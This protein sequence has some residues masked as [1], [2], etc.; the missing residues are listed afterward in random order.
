MAGYAVLVE[1]LGS[2]EDLRA[3][4]PEIDRRARM[5]I[6]KATD[7][8]RAEGARDIKEQVAFPSTYLTGGQGAAR[9]SKQ[10]FSGRL[11]GEVTGRFRPTSLA[12]FVKGSADPARTRG[13]TLKFE[14]EP[15]RIAYSGRMFLMRL[16]AGN[17]DIETQNNLGV[18][19]RL[20]P[21][22]QVTGRKDGTP[23]KTWRGLAF[24]YGPSVDQVFRDVAKDNAPATLLIL[25]Q[26]FLRLM[27]VKGI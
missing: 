19:I 7:K 14:V 1:G 11:R 22:E 27:N 24:L 26:E 15:G 5:A 16:R 17:A 18:A 6:S 10:V 13:K 9:L 2:L 12:R 20:R 21:G 4:G 8:A 3:L 25:E 23:V